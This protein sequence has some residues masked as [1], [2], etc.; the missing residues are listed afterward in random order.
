MGILEERLNQAFATKKNDIKSFIWKGK[1]VEVNGEYVQEKKRLVDCT[2]EELQRNYDYC[3]Q[4]LYNE[5]KQKPGRYVLISIINDQM[6]RCNCELFLRWLKSENKKDR[7]TFVSEVKRI[8]DM[9]D[10]RE[11][12]ENTNKIPISAMTSNIPDE[13]ASLP[14]SIIIDGGLDKLGV[15]DSKHITLSFIAKQ[16]IWFTTE[17]LK[18]LSIKDPETGELR[19]R[20]QV[21]KENLAL[22]DK[23][24][25]KITPK[26]LTYAQLRAMITL[27]N[28]K[29]SELTTE[30]LK[31]LRNRILFD[32]SRECNFHAKQWEYRMKQI[33]MVAEYKNFELSDV[34][35]L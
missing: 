15:F 25:L 13:F 21:V 31:T 29:Y 9:P 6:V 4:M 12:A 32:L 2:N 18:E 16:G 27:R 19:D 10:N 3:K 17:E 11:A 7:F 28:K 22:K 14:V 34:S 23:V 30:Q 26:G 1:K 33:E 5:D 20:L 8:L 35:N 24:P